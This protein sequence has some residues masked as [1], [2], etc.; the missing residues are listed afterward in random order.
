MIASILEVCKSCLVIS[1]LFVLAD[2]V[3][4]QSFGPYRTVYP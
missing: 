1:D 2:Y 3:G 4:I